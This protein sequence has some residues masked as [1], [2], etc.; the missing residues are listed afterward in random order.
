MHYRLEPARCTGRQLILGAIAAVCLGLMALSAPPGS[1]SAASSDQ[2]EDEF[3][4]YL[5]RDGREY[6]VVI[7]LLLAAGDPGHAA[8]LTAARARVVADFPGAVLEEAVPGTATA[9]FVRYPYRWPGTSVA[10]GYN[11]AGRPGGIAGDDAAVR[12]SAAVWNVAGAAIGFRD[13]QPSNAGLGGCHNAPDGQNVV[14]WARLDGSVLART[15]TWYDTTGLAIEFDIEISPAFPWT[16]GDS[17]NADLQSVVGHELGHALGLNHSP[18]G[19]ALMFDTYMITTIRRAP[20]ADDIAGLIAIYGK[21]PTAAAAAAPATGMQLYRG[22]NLTTW[23]GPDRDVSQAL[24]GTGMVE[25]VYT[26]DP[27]TGA[28][29]RY[30]PGAAAYTNTLGALRT[31]QAYWF[32]GSRDGWL[33][34]AQ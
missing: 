12:A 21:A 9:Q 3:V 20:Q 15:C 24:V 4:L 13:V 16:T 8:S 17:P 11:P 6:R 23:P 1:A 2:H 33:S 26:V 25:A 19:A 34:V 7:S 27:A 32:I 28:W 31:G 30:I 29:L 18:D 10:L 14:G 5:E 22:A